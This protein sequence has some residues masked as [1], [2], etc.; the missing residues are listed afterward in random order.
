[1]KGMNGNKS[2]KK[3]A[4]TRGKAVNPNLPKKT[5]T[6]QARNKGEEKKG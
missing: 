5:A 3:G 1:M 6:N 2:V 4:T